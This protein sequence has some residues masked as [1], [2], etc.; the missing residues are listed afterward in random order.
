MVPL[1]DWREIGVSSRCCGEYELVGELGLFRW[2]V[3]VGEEVGREW[4]LVERGFV[5]G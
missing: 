2:F 5:N 1:F 4:L 3:W